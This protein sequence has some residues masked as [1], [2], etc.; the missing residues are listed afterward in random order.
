MPWPALLRP[1]LVLLPPQC[2][3]CGAAAD[4]DG[5]C[6]GC[7]DDAPYATG[8]RCRLCAV[9][10]GSGELCGVCLRRPPRFDRCLAACRYDWP[11]DALIPAFKYGG[12]LTLARPLASL[13]AEAARSERPD[14]V[15]A[16]PLHPSRQ[17]QRGFNQSLLLAELVTRR[18]G[19]RLD[20][21]LLIRSRPT[22]PQASLS[23][24]QRRRAVRNAFTV[25]R[26]LDGLHLAVVDDV[27]TSGA[28][29]DEVARA[30]KRAGARRVEGW[31]VARAD[32]L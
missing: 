5:L 2:V 17:R 14:L 16:M 30:L 12:D 28:S 26:R 9:A 29:L 31:V 15:L 18:L 20:R 1:L 24:S 8:P 32:R 25:R 3:L 19:L 10:L 6:A 27:M 23:L 21:S 22:P 7:R 4:D 11:L 13:L